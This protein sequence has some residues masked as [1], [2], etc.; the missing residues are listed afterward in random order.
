MYCSILW[1]K[2]DSHSLVMR[3]NHDFQRKPSLVYLIHKITNKYLYMDLLSRNDD[4]QRAIGILQNE[5]YAKTN[6]LNLTKNILT[7]A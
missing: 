4:I 5:A 2:G 3:K 7:T 6:D 1:D